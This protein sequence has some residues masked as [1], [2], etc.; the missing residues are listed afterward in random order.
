MW[1]LMCSLSEFKMLQGAMAMPYAGNNGILINA[2]FGWI[3]DAKKEPSIVAVLYRKG[4]D[5]NEA[6]ANKEFAYLNF[7]NKDNNEKIEDLIDE[8][9]S[10]LSNNYDDHHFEV[11]EENSLWIRIFKSKQ[12]PTTE[13]TIF[14]DFGEFI[15]FIVLFSQDNMMD[16]NLE[17]MKYL[18]LSA[19]AFKVAVKF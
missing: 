5:L 1:E 18:L 8:Q 19:N 16:K 7:W 4:Y 17:K 3:I 11:R 6:F 14:R 13:I 12:Y 9:N 15:V 10:D 2:P